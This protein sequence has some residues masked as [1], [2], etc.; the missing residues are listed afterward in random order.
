DDRPSTAMQ[1]IVN[2]VTEDVKAYAYEGPVSTL[3]WTFLGDSRGEVLGG[4]DGNDFLNLLGGDDAASGGAGDDVLDGGS[5]SNWLIGGSGKDTF[6]VD[7]RGT[8]VTWSTVTDLEQGEWSTLWGYKEGTSTLRWEEMDGAEGYK[9]AT[10]HCDIDGNGTI[11]ASM[12]FAGK[13]VGAMTMT[14]GTMGDQNYIAFIN[15]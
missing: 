2:G 13:S 6:F 14:T 15:L 10:V 1:R 9:G 3:Q 11:D 7:G 5:G 8:E 12:T 4:S